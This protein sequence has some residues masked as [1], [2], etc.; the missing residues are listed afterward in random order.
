M[1][2]LKR[3]NLTYFAVDDNV[4]TPPAALSK[5]QID[6]FVEKGVI[7]VRNI[8]SADEVCA[9]RVGLHCFLEKNGCD[10]GNLHLTAQ[11]ISGL[12]TT[13]GSGGV[14]DVF[15]EDWK[16][17]INE[18]SRVWDVMSQLWGA[19]FGPCDDGLY[20]H[21]HGPFNHRKGFMYIDRVCFRL[22]DVILNIFGKSKK[23]RLQRSLYPHLDCCPHRMFSSDKEHPKWRPIQAFIALT[24]TLHTEMGGFEACCG[25]HR[26][27]DEWAATRRSSV[28]V[29]DGSEHSVPPP[30][31]GD[32]TP[33]RPKDDQEILDAMSHIPCRA[34]DMVCWDYRIPHGNSRRNESESSREVLYIGFLPPVPTN[35]LYAREQ[36]RRMRT[37]L[38]PGDQW[39]SSSV[40]RECGYS[41][42]R[43]GRL[44]MGIDDDW[45]TY[46]EA[47]EKLA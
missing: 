29:V 22:P 31:V 19:T 47:Q 1:C 33:I 36:L 32:F 13:G 5:E 45:E 46:L 26:R 30:C 7:V 43:L 28:A 12:S 34:G 40:K 25:F 44:L 6:E 10:P 3:R 24:D 38:L 8:L 41:F 21:P 9:A 42:S 39:H 2:I 11:H 27:F 4:A 16:L 20:H 14:I 17:K 37:G 15:Y 23:T 35:Q 18:N